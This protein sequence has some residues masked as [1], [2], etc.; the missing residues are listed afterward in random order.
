ILIVTQREDTLSWLPE[1]MKSSKSN[2]TQIECDDA[3]KGQSYSLR[4]GLVAAEALAA[5][6]IVVLLADQP[7][8]T[9]TMI[10]DIV[11]HFVENK[12]LL[13]VGTMHNQ[14]ISPPMLLSSALFPEIAHLTGDSGANKIIREKR[15]QGYFIDVN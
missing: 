6:A 12:Q 2:W 5:D 15:Q 8:I 3:V 11:Q 4:C 1:E 13:F 9:V 7:Y 10:N 14:I